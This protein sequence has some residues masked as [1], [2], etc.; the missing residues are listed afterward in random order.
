[1]DVIKTRTLV[2]LVLVALFPGLTY[3]PA[4]AQEM[5][6]KSELTT[7]VLNGQVWGLYR[8]NRKPL[9]DVRIELQQY[10]NGERRTV[11]TAETDT[12]GNFDFGKI[13]SGNYTLVA[14]SYGYVSTEADVKVVK[15]SKA[16]E[17]R[18]EIVIVLGM[19][20]GECGY[21]EVKK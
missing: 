13:K 15:L 5:C 17:K 1:M 6:I 8:G 3:K 12:N 11:A 7:T 10:R 21:V 18:A 14:S 20:L 4:R 9:S 19:A 2:V 16:K